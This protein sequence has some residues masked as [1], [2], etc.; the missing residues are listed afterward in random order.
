MA[1][2]SD[3][4]VV[5]QPVQVTGLRVSYRKIIH[6]GD[7][8]V[9]LV[10]TGNTPDVSDSSWSGWASIPSL[11]LARSEIHGRFLQM[12]FLFRSSD[13]LNSPTLMFVSAQT[14]YFLKYDDVSGSIKVVSSLNHPLVQSALSF[15][16]EDPQNARLQEFRKKYNLDSVLYA[17]ST[18]F[19]KL[20]KLKTWVAKQWKWHLLRPEQNFLAWDADQILTYDSLGTRGGFCIDY[21]I[22]FMEAAQSFG[23]PVRIVIMN[24]SVWGG[25]EVPEVWSEDYGKW[26]MLDPNFD[27]YFVD[28]GTGV[29]YNALE[30]HRIFLNAYY[31]HSSIDRDSWSRKNLVDMVKARGK[32]EIPVMCITGGGADGG[33]LTHYA[34]L[35]PMIDLYPYTGGFGFLSAGYLRY[36]PRSNFLSQPY[37]IPVNEGRTHWPWTGYY[38]WYDERTP[39]AAEDMIFTTRENDL[40][41]NLN[42]VDFSAEAEPGGVLRI[43]LNTDSPYFNHYEIEMNGKMVDTRNCALSWNLAPGFNVLKMTVVDSM[44]NHGKNSTLKLIYLPLQEQN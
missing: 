6:S 14:T 42:E 11:E 12:K 35:D 44:G 4:G 20:L 43:S 17:A 3:I 25:H 8:L 32:E 21:A 38:C 27:T 13:P 39:A 23:I 41:W 26:I 29:P 36:M 10:R 2:N 24:Y 22:V 9:L 31:P 30:L 15:K 37:P 18:E 40:Y 28:P 33:T 19:E 16:F 34:W 1:A 5:R 7:S